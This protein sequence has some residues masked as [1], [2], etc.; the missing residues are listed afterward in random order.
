[1]TCHQFPEASLHSKGDQR[2]SSQ[3][4]FRVNFRHAFHVGH[5]T[6]QDRPVE[7]SFHAQLGPQ[8][9]YDFRTD[10]MAGDCCHSPDL[11]SL[12]VI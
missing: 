10:E 4:V 3:D 11:Y 7:P 8:L 1:M 2:S 9:S 6:R 5:G 12:E